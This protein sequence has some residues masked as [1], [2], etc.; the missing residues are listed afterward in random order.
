MMH[1]IGNEE[2]GSLLDF[3]HGNGCRAVSASRH[4]V[5]PFSPTTQNSA[6]II[7]QNN[8]QNHTLEVRR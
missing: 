2:A 8:F 4:R 3:A 7:M 5:L 6:Q 1:H